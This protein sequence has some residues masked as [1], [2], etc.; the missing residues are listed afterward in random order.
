MDLSVVRS[1]LYHHAI[2]PDSI[3]MIVMCSPAGLPHM[4][5]YMLRQRRKMLSK[6]PEAEVATDAAT[7]KKKD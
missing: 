7:R 6:K 3:K 4:Y 2:R 1:T 5:L